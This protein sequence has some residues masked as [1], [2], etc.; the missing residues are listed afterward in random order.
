MPYPF[1]GALVQP[2]EIVNL[3]MWLW[4]W[5]W[6]RLL[7]WFETVK[8]VYMVARNLVIVDGIPIQW[9]SVKYLIG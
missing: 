8:V 7:L 9:S 6:F 4:L 1:R 2:V 3:C 5:V